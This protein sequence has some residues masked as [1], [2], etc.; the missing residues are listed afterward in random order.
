MLETIVGG[1][2]LTFGA[3]LALTGVNVP[4]G[5][6]MIAAGAVSYTHLDV[7]KR[8]T[9]G[10]VVVATRQAVTIFNKKGV[11]IEQERDAD[12]R[13]NDICLLYTSRCV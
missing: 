2:L 13:K 6:A 4:L 10:T 8:Q 5:V 11:E 3:I 12:H 7:Y 1:A 9:K